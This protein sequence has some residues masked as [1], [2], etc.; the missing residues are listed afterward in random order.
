MISYETKNGYGELLQ[1]DSERAD[2][3]M[4]RIHGAECGT[5]IIGEMRLV[6]TDGEC[7]CD[8]STL[9]DGEYLPHLLTQEKE[10]QLEG[11]CKEGEM[12]RP[13]KTEE[14]VIRKLLL[15]VKTLEGKLEKLE[16]R[17]DEL[18]SSVYGYSLFD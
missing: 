17:A 12:I 2:S 3:I 10:I 5:L 13:I 9:P 1:F 11:L 7:R 6:V 18:E 8:L 15:R 14:W 16:D 4:I